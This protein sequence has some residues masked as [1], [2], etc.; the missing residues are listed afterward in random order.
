MLC[1]SEK[2]VLQCR[3]SLLRSPFSSEDYPSFSLLL[4]DIYF[5]RKVFLP[6]RIH[7]VVLTF[8]KPYKLFDFPRTQ[9]LCHPFP[10][11]EWFPTLLSV[12]SLLHHQRSPSPS[13]EPKTHSVQTSAS[14]FT[15]LNV[16]CS[17]KTSEV[18][19]SKIPPLS[20]CQ[21]VDSVISFSP[22]YLRT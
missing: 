17:S 10:P 4:Y 22:S 8:L 18:P 16:K 7:L 6:C 9:T 21:S 19:L 20:R 11:L 15:G 13:Y 2:R 1:L 14:N 5:V 12:S 3:T